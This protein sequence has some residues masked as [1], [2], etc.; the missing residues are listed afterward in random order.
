MVIVRSEDIKGGKPVV[1]GSRV[2]VEAVVKRFYSADMSV[3][4]ISDSLNIPLDSVEE[5]LRFH[6]REF[7]RRVEA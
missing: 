6:N 3:S 5:A 4:E 7:S 1:E 2:T